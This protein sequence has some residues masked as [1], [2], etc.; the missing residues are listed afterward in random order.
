MNRTLP[1]NK[2][3]KQKV[4][5]ACCQDYFGKSQ[6]TVRSN[7]IALWIMGKRA[8]IK[9]TEEEVSDMWAIRENIEDVKY[10]LTL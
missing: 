7:Q 8:G 3:E 9:L 10:T 5:I 2:S 1:K 4:I 6:N